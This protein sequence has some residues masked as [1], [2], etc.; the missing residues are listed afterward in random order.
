M[1]DFALTKDMSSI[2]EDT[3][4]M[5][6]A[7]NGFASIVSYLLRDGQADPSFSNN[8]VSHST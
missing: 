8:K 2:Q 3:A 5:L 4:L 1:S 6:A 7:S